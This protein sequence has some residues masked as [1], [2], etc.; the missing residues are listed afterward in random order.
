MTIRPDDIPFIFNLTQASNR[1]SIVNSVKAGLLT[2]NILPSFP[3][4]KTVDI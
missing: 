2:C 3:F 4:L 1:E